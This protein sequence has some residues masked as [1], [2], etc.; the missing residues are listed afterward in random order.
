MADGIHAADDIAPR[1]GFI[2]L[3]DVSNRSRI[4]QDIDRFFELGKVFWADQDGGRVAVPGQHDALMLTLD[5][6]NKLRE[7]IAN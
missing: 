7:V 1:V 2:S 3:A 5:A 6:V 4:A